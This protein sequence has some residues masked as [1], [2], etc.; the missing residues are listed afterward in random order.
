MSGSAE[1]LRS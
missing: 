1:Q